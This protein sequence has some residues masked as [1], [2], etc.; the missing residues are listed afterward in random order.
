MK[1]IL[2]RKKQLTNNLDR[3]E[4]CKNDC[5]LKTNEKNKKNLQI[6]ILFVIFNLLNK[7]CY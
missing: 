4:K 2:F 6:T 3:L 7:R 5:A 1:M